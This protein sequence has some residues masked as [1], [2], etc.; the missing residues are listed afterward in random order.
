MG[1]E[2]FHSLFKT[3]NLC[4]KVILPDNSGQ[5]S[6]GIG[7]CPSPE[8]VEAKPTATT[9]NDNGGQVYSSTDQETSCVLVCN[10]LRYLFGPDQAHFIFTQRCGELPIARW[11]LACWGQGPNRVATNGSTEAQWDNHGINER[12]NR[13]DN[14][15]RQWRRFCLVWCTCQ[16][17]RILLGQQ[18]EHLLHHTPHDGYRTS[19]AIGR[20]IVWWSNTTLSSS[21]LPDKVIRNRHGTHP[22]GHST[23]Q[24]TRCRRTKQSIASRREWVGVDPNAWSVL[25]RGLVVGLYDGCVQ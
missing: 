17:Q 12:H 13:V 4:E 24:P 5:T 1:D 22:D 18:L 11:W 23:I 20:C 21:V 9:R 16:F 14:P 7:F 15:Q 25:S 6:K 19:Q 3:V 2:R 10:N 8:R